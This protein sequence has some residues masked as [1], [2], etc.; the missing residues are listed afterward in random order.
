MIHLPGTRFCGE[1]RGSTPTDEREGSRFSAESGL[2]QV[3]PTRGVSLDNSYMQLLYK[4]R[5]EMNSRP[6][7]E[8]DV[9]WAR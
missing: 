8:E 5:A 2:G 6:R 9:E 1:M 7:A 4:V 3:G